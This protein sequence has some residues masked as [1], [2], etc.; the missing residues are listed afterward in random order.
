MQFFKSQR[1]LESKTYIYMAPPP[2]DPEIIPSIYSIELREDQ[3]VEWHWTHLP[4]GNAVVTGYKIR[5]KNR[6]N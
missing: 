4:D 6:E 2:T 3:E 1:S 5:E